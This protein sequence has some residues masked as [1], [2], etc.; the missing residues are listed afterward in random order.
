MWSISIVLYHIY[1]TS[2][3][4]RSQFNFFSRGLR[5]STPPFPFF[6]LPHFLM[7]Q[8]QTTLMEPLLTHNLANAKPNYD[9]DVI[10]WFERVS[11]N[12]AFVQTQLLTQILKQN[13]GVE[14][15]NKWLGNYNILEMDACALE[16]L[17][18][19]VVPL[20]SHADFEPF[21]QRIADGDTAPLLT[22][23]PIT[24]L[25]L[26]YHI[27]SI[28]FFF[29]FLV[30]NFLHFMVMFITIKNQNTGHSDRDHLC[31][32]PSH[33]AKSMLVLVFFYS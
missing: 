5:T 20:A 28:T 31:L 17:F 9:Y 22:Q 24:T 15:L 2:A 25:S 27:I 6:F 19:S 3:N 11:H 18:S 29:C 10:N 26:R 1:E 4:I 16:S 23:Q 8:H 32:S 33:S 30:L 12:A 21:I 13:Y 14:Y 7:T